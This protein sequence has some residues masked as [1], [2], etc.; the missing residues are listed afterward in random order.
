MTRTKPDLAFSIGAATAIALLAPAVMLLGGCDQPPTTPT[1]SQASAQATAVVSQQ[2]LQSW[3]RFRLVYGLRADVEW[4]LAVANDPTASSE[5]FGVPLLPSELEQV[6]EAIV[7]AQGLV[8]IAR[9]YA[10]DFPEFAGTWLELPRVVLAFSD[11]VP[12][13]RVEVDALFGD[14]AIVREVQFSLVQLQLFIK[15]MGADRAWFSSV[16]AEVVDFGI[17]EALN[18]VQVH[19]RSTD[20]AIEG[21]ARERFGD[22]GWMQFTYDGPGPWKGAVGDLEVTVVDTDGQPAAVECLLGTVDPRVQDE[23]FS[24]AADGKCFYR[25]LAAVKW[26]LRVDYDGQ[27]GGEPVITDFLVPPDGVE[28]A[29]VVVGE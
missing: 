23:K 4:A 16:G 12:E 11:R 7:S 2:E 27:P 1:T 17:D 14:K 20:P 25:D 19:L 24:F 26:S 10:D 6:G 13:H 8:S 9:G 28:R 29:T 5:I 22:T 18:S 3:I 15:T 21:S